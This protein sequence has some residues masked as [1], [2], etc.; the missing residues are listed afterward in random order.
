MTLSRLFTSG[1]DLIFKSSVI[2]S[3]L[4]FASALRAQTATDFSGKWAFDKSKSNAGEGAYFPKENEVTLDITQDANNITINKTIKQKGVVVIT[5]SNKYTL[6][7]KESVTGDSSQPIKTVAKWSSDKKNLT[8]TTSMTIDS[9]EY[10]TDDT[11]SLSN[12]D[13]ILTIQSIYK[14]PK[15]GREQILVYLKK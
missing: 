9:V 11:Y 7:G 1:K 3:I 4:L 12:G 8:I 2:L 15:A 13:K 10:R 6:D 5:V 14:D